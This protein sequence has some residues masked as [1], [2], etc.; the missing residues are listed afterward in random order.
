MLLRR[1]Q[2]E[3]GARERGGEFEQS[4]RGQDVDV[5]LLLVYVGVYMNAYMTL[6]G[7]NKHLNHRSGLDRLHSSDLLVFLSYSPQHDLYRIWTVGGNLLKPHQPR[8]VTN[9][10]LGHTNLQQEH[11]AGVAACLEAGSR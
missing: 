3:L 9:S 6:Q 10:D 8:S 2:C 5:E 4:L 7:C 11:E 1:W